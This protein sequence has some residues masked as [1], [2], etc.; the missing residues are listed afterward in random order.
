MS[1]QAILKVEKTEL[2]NLTI[3]LDEHGVVKA[4]K[5]TVQLKEG[6]DYVFIQGKP[7]I[8]VTGMDNLNQVM[9][10]SILTPAS[11]TVDGKQVPNPYIERDSNGIPISITIRKI[12]VG[13]S[14]TG[15]L[16][17]VDYVLTYNRR[18][19]LLQSLAKVAD[20]APSACFL[21]TQEDNPNQE[22]ISIDKSTWKKTDKGKS[23]KTSEATQVGG[24]GRWKFYPVDDVIGYWVNLSAFE[25][26]EVMRDYVNILT[27]FERRAQSI[28][29]RNAMAH[30]PACGGAYTEEGGRKTVWGIRYEQDPGRLQKQMEALASG[31]AITDILEADVVEIHEENPD[32]TAEEVK[33]VAPTHDLEPEREV[34][35]ELFD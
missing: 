25:I 18:S 4:F 28:C 15:Q 10:L 9:G 22:T 16:V 19:L 32:L 27:T 24:K 17:P 29:A 20:K 31:E 12:A 1:E 33:Q 7:F 2:G 8:T 6:R 11:T 21:G 30:H 14:P 35:N 26:Q 34:D 3:K 5:S 13:N 23:Y